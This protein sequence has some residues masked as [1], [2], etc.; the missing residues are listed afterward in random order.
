MSKFEISLKVTWLGLWFIKL[1]NVMFTFNHQSIHN[2]YINKTHTKFKSNTINMKM[3]TSKILLKKSF[4]TLFLIFIIT[5][6]YILFMFFL[7]LQ[8]ALI[9]FLH[10]SCKSLGFDLTLSTQLIYY[11]I[12]QIFI[13]ITLHLNLHH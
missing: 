2:N 1:L 3:E 13:G 5:C 4:Q 7:I 12:L 10:M 11:L 8:F 6:S 9:L